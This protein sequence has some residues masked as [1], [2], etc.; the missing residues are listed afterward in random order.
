MTTPFWNESRQRDI[1]ALLNEN[2]DALDA[3]NPSWPPERQAEERT[4]LHAERLPLVDEAERP[5]L[6][7][8]AGAGFRVASVYDLPAL[9]CDYAAA[10]PLLLDHLDRTY[11]FIIREGIARALQCRSAGPFWDEL[12][13]RFRRE[14]RDLP[15]KAVGASQALAAALAEACPVARL[16]ELLG[17]LRDRSLGEDRIL[18]IGRLWRAGKGAYREA[19]LDLADDPDLR[20]EIDRKRRGKGPRD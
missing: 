17:L 15:Y 13:A 12:V 2:G 6:A 3:I 10:F 19:I 18:L 14:P 5:L 20:I 4:R 11:P 7:A 8:L 16:P 1:I 9:P